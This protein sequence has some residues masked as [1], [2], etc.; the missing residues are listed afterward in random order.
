MYFPAAVKLDL[1]GL[2]CC[3]QPKPFFDSII[4]KQKK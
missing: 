1:H 2:K 3:F 4:I